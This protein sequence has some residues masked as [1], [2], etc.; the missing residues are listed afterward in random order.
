LYHFKTFVWQLQWV[1]CVFFV[2][3]SKQIEKLWEFAAAYGRRG[4][5]EEAAH[6]P[7]AFSD[8]T[9]FAFIMLFRKLALRASDNASQHGLAL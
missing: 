3:I 2:K 9:A 1:S 6:G 4:S 5:L 7:A 8:F